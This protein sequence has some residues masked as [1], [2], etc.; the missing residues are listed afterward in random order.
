LILGLALLGTTLPGIDT[1]SDLLYRGLIK[2]PHPGCH[3]I[4]PIPHSDPGRNTGISGQ[5]GMF[6]Q[7]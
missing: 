7:I 4:P 2:V 1:T 5:F 3:A 6:H